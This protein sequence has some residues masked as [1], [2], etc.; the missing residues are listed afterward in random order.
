MSWWLHRNILVFEHL[1][2]TRLQQHKIAYEIDFTYSRNLLTEFAY[3][4]ENLFTI[5]QPCQLGQWINIMAKL[6]ASCKLE[7]GWRTNS[8]TA[9]NLT[10]EICMGQTILIM[11]MKSQH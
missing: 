2:K 8:R 7:H 1:N 3:C 11:V 6:L 9:P 5:K 10:A 4:K